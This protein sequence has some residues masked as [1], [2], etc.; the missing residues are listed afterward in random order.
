MYNNKKI[1]QE[2]SFSL[3]EKLIDTFN[4]YFLESVAIR[5]FLSKFVTEKDQRMFSSSIT[6]FGKQTPSAFRDTFLPFIS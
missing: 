4:K 3:Q 1:S 5:F 6:H 2:K